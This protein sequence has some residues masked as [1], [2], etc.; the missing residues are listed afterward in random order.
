MPGSE[1]MNQVGQVNEDAKAG[2]LGNAEELPE[3]NAPLEARAPSEEIAEETPVVEATSGEEPVV[4]VEEPT[5]IRIGEREF[6][7]EKEA[8]RYAEELESKNNQ[9]EAYNQGIR[10]TL[11]TVNPAQPPPAEDDNF[12]E[13]FY[14]DPKGTLA[15]IK[16]QATDEAL[17]LFN[18]QTQREA[19]WNQ[20]LTANPDIRRKDAERI[21]AEPEN[22]AVLSKLTD[23]KKAMSLLAQKTRAEYAEIEELR[24]PRTALPATSGA[25][26]PSS[27]GA[28]ARVTQ[29][30]KDEAPLDF[31]SQLKR[32]KGQG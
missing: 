26:M 16:K 6:T 1:M 11:G 24:K 27:G 15:S 23:S 20:F 2:K 8:L 18:Q 29:A 9:L 14:A 30:K 10:D 7:S 3:G 17:R 25:R 22:W 32:M 12:D 4:A 28:P 21:L 19:L 5:L 31:V 13:K